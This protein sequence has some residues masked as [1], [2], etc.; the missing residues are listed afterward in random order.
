MLINS[1]ITII[2]GIARRTD[3]VIEISLILVAGPSIHA[4]LVPSL[5]TSF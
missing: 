3:T 1:A 2:S 5:L 4:A